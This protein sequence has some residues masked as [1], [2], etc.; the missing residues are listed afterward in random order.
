MQLGLKMPGSSVLGTEGW[1][2]LASEAYLEGGQGS[3]C[4]GRQN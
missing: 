3:G 1:G 2:W 4:Q